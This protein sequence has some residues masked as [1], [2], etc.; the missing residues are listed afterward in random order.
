[1]G[2]AALDRSYGAQSYGASSGFRNAH[3]F[4]TA[5]SVSSLSIRY[6]WRYDELELCAIGCRRVR[7][8]TE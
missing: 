7:Q 3:S 2:L 8:H 4:V 5:I 6:L 1:M